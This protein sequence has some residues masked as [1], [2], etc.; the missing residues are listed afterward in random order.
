MDEMPP[1]VIGLESKTVRVAAYHPQWPALYEAESA[2]VRG[3]LGNLPVIIEH[4]GSTAVPGLAAKPI[5]DMLAGRPPELDREQVIERITAAGYSYRGEQ[6]IPGRDFF[7]RGEP[8]A[9]HLHLTEIGSGFWRDHRAFRDYLLAHPE[10]RDA[11][12]ALKV[13]LAE[14]FPRDR[15]RYIEAKTD[16]VNDILR[17]ARR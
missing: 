4:T 17:R 3:W 8:R 2:R 11:Y 10:A 12:G 6:G 13:E 16:F 15:E 7:R 9:Y 5:I 1:P 14:R